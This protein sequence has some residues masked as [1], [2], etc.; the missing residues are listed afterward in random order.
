MQIEELKDSLLNV[1]SNLQKF[2]LIEEYSKQIHKDKTI[3]ENIK[4]ILDNC[5]TYEDLKKNSYLC[6][7][8]IHVLIQ[9]RRP[10]SM[11]TLIQY[12][13]SLPEFVP[14]TFVEFLGKLL[15]FFGKI[16]IGPS[17]ELAEFPSGTPQ[18][19][20]GIQ[21]LC[22]LFLDGLLG[23]ENYDYLRKLIYDFRNDYYFTDYLIE[24]VKSTR[25]F[26]II[27]QEK[28]SLI[29]EESTTEEWIIDDSI[30]IEKK[31]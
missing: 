9:S 17:K 24:M 28:E 19:A 30:L 31:E 12:I 11:Y 26:R 13:K 18:H 5:K 10:E 27:T 6:S 21:T 8:C 7:C 2:Q 23:E 22:N 3:L 16:I 1:K 25:E 4:I 14:I 29:Q 15:P 20:I